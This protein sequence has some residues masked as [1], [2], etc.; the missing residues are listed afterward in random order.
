METLGRR[1]R[2]RKTSGTGLSKCQKV[3]R[4]YFA[5]PVSYTHLTL[6]TT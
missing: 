4:G 1:L 6:P 5:R 2:S 3:S